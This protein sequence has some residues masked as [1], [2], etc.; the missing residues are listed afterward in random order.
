MGLGTDIIVDEEVAPSQEQKSGSVVEISGIKSVR[1]PDK[2][3]DIISRVVVERLLPYFV[4]RE[5]NCPRPVIRD[6]KNPAAPLSLND[7]PRKDASQT[8]ATKVDGGTITTSARTTVASEQ[9]VSVR[10]H[11]GVRGT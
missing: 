4:D 8:D 7:Y 2:R 9:R 5:R 6:A 3:L 1:F 10:Q 11:F